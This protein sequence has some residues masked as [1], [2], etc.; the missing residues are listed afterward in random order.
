MRKTS[1]VYIMLIE[2]PD[3][4]RQL[5]TLSIDSMIT[6]KCILKGYL[7]FYSTDNEY[8]MCLCVFG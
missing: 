7:R 1:K 4:K 6:L 2:V 3:G 8:V 5:E